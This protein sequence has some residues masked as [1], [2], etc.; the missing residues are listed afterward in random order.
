[1]KKWMKGILGVVF[2]LLISGCGQEE[3]E[4]VFEEETYEN[5]YFM[6]FKEVENMIEY[7]SIDGSTV[8]EV[9]DNVDELFFFFENQEDNYMDYL[10]LFVDRGYTLDGSDGTTVSTISTTNEDVCIEY[11]IVSDSV[12]FEDAYPEIDITVQNAGVRI[13]TIE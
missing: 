1:M 7:L 11:Y 3:E 2:V 13:T 4:V 9:E 8:I 12:W 10:Q 6:N 5:E